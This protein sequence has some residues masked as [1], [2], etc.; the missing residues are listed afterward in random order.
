[1]DTFILYIRKLTGRL[2]HQK[3][4]IQSLK[5]VS[6]HVAHFCDLKYFI[7]TVIIEYIIITQLMLPTVLVLPSHVAF[8]MSPQELSF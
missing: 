8:V 7:V 2:L 5:D 1:M 4:L 3:L 6:T